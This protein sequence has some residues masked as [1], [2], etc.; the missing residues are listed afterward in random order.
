MTFERQSGR[1]SA[2]LIVGGNN[3]GAKRMGVNGRIHRTAT[4]PV[5]RRAMAS[6]DIIRKE[7]IEM[8]RVR[9]ELAQRDVVTDPQKLVGLTPRY[10][11]R[12]GEPVREGDAR[13]PIVIVRN[14]PVII[15]LQAGNMTLTAQGRAT[16]DGAKGEIIRVTNMQ[17][18]KVIEAVV[19]GPDT[20]TVALGSHRAL[21]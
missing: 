3:A 6:G 13:P 4:L 5:L 7:D 20:V 17:S 18:K 21:N 12:A 2:L 19:A 16:E 11:L 15:V 14:S 1:F 10:R 8:A 9:E